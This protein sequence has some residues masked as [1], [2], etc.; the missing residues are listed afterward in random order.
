MSGRGGTR[1]EI[2]TVPAG[3]RAVVRHFSV[4]NWGAAGASG[5]LEVHGIAVY[6]RPFQAQFVGVFEDIRFT[7]YEDETIVLTVNG[8]DLSYSVDGF[9]FDD[10]DG[11]PDDADNV[12]SM[13][14]PADLLPAA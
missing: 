2:F 9:L 6:Y 4:Y 5:F 8:T 1:N 12:I 14:K 13:T 10:P 3:R 11:R 7:A